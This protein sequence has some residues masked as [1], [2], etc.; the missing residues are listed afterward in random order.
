MI[1]HTQ[2]TGKDALTMRTSPIFKLATKSLIRR[3]ATS[4]SFVLATPPSL[5]SSRLTTFIHSAN[6]IICNETEVNQFRSSKQIAISL[7]CIATRAHKQSNSPTWY[8]SPPSDVK[9]FSQCGQPNLDF[10]PTFFATFLGCSSSDGSKSLFSFASVTLAAAPRFGAAL[11]FL[12]KDRLRFTILSSSSSSFFG[13][14]FNC[15]FFRW[16]AGLSFLS[17]SSSSALTSLSELM[18]TQSVFFWIRKLWPF[19]FHNLVLFPW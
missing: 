8:F 17:G 19:R 13:A 3:A 12:G 7:H 2:R 14:C 6:V 11:R 16:A 4:I 10:P 9:D 15:F 5:R 1:I 18:L